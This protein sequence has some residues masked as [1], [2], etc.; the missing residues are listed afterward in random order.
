MLNWKT[1]LAVAGVALVCGAAGAWAMHAFTSAA[2]DEDGPSSSKQGGSH[3]SENANSSKSGGNKSSGGKKQGDADKNGEQSAGASAADI[4]GFTAADDAET[5]KK[6]IKRLA[7]RIE[8]VDRRIDSLQAP[9]AE[10]PPVVHTL[11]VQFADLAK[12][13]DELAET[14]AEL[15]RLEHRLSSLEQQLKTLR[16]AQSIDG[17]ALESQALDSL[18]ER[19]QGEV[20]AGSAA[21]ERAREDFPTAASS[22]TKGEAADDVEDNGAT[23]NLG[24]ELFQK[25]RYAQARE[26]F[27]RLQ[28]ARPNDARVWYFS[29]LANGLITRDWDGKTKELFDKGVARERAGDPPSERI[30]KAFADLKSAEAR[31]WLE[32]FRRRANDESQ[33]DRARQEHNR[34]LTPESFKVP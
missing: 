4:P 13:V 2:Q 17:T 26:V 20:P 34:R 15:R 24:I 22:D 23:M 14:P 33:A 18:F 3:P 16:D 9:Q 32:R 27:R 6:Q 8:Q 19:D 10:T 29:A 21:E 7:D 28:R 1:L 31:E 12:E 11:Q 30:D 25:E 5:L